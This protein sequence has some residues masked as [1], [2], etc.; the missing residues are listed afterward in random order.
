MLNNFNLNITGENAAEMHNAITSALVSKGILFADEPAKEV[1]VDEV[2]K[3]IGLPRDGSRFFVV[4]GLLIEVTSEQKEVRPYQRYVNIWEEFLDDHGISEHR[5]PF[6]T[7][8]IYYLQYEN[9]LACEGIDEEDTDFSSYIE[10]IVCLDIENLPT[11]TNTNINVNDIEIITVYG[12]RVVANVKDLINKVVSEQR[13]FTMM[14]ETAEQ[15]K[16]EFE[17]KISYLE[18]LLA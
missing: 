18:S 1:F 16:A 14:L 4:S 5:L 7:F 10:E 8:H 11:Q 13:A 9:W 6:T 17:S 15:K 12:G 3:L 2:S